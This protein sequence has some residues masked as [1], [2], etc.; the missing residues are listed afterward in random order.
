[1]NVFLT[2]VGPGV[3]GR[4][5]PP[6][7]TGSTGRSGLDGSNGPSGLPGNSGPAGGPGQPGSQGNSGPAGNTIYIFGTFN[8]KN[9]RQPILMFYP[10][11]RIYLFLATQNC[12]H[13]NECLLYKY[14][15]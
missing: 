13:L 3:P 14:T 12:I 4:T 2:V 15:Y 5:G 11:T 8:T 9:R 7:Q 6:G 1:M 10:E